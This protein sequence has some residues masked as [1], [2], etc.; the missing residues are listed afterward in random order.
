MLLTYFAP[1]ASTRAMTSSRHEF[2]DGFRLIVPILIAQTPF[3]FIVG[4]TSVQK[5]LSVLEATIMSATVFAGAGQ[6]LA[7]EVWHQPKA[8]LLVMLAAASVNIRFL[9]QT[10][11][12]GPKI[13]HFPPFKRW[14]AV[15]T[16][17]DPAWGMS[18]MRHL[19]R[20]IRPAFLAG[21]SLPIYV[22]WVAA[23]AVGAFAGQ[24]IDDPAR[25]G[26]D[27][28]FVCIFISLVLPFWKR[29]GAVPVAATSALVAIACKVVGFG[30]LYVFIGA[31][32]GV[33]VAG[34][35]AHRNAGAADGA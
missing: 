31:L 16:M 13:S 19:T 32:A 1:N 11:S 27:F 17:T 34:F 15:A 33:A 4:A 5:G 6:M 28:A 29:S 25:Y 23:T 18:E 7:L 14:L 21:I 30:G 12:I 24:F 9:L 2:L 3:G 22:I 26:L 8:W 20:P 35:M 10:A